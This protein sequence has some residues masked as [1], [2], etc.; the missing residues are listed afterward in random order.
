MAYTL[1]NVLHYHGVTGTGDTLTDNAREA[2]II[3][4]CLG[5]GSIAGINP[6]TVAPCDVEPARRGT[7]DAIDFDAFEC[8]EGEDMIVF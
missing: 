5:C 3:W 2:G 7:R 4:A 8:C 1:T 6:L